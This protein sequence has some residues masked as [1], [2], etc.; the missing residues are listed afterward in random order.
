MLGWAVSANP[1]HSLA[2]IVLRVMRLRPLYVIGCFAVLGVVLLIANR[3]MPF[4]RNDLVYARAAQHVI[5]HGY[6]PRPIVA[7]SSLSYDKPVGFAWLGAPF[8]RAFGSHVGLRIVSFLGVLLFLLASWRFVRALRVLPEEELP[9]R[10]AE[11]W[12]L[13]LVAFNPIVAYQVWSAHPDA[14]FAALVLATW[15]LAIELVREPQRAVWRKATLLALL[16]TSGLVLKN[17]ALILLA[18][19]PLYVALNLRALHAHG[20]R[21][22]QLVIALGAALFAGAGFAW[23]AKSGH[24]PFAHIAG[25]GGGAGQYGKGELA[26]GALGTLLQ[27]AL[28]LVLNLGLALVFLARRV[29]LRRELVIPLVAFLAPYVAGLMAFPTTYYNMRYFL[30]LLPLVA[31]ACVHGARAAAPGFARSIFA[32][33]LALGLLWIAV[34]N[35]APLHALAEPAIPAWTFTAGY[36]KQG[37][38]DNL[39]M[40]Q[41][42][43]R[44]AEIERANASVGHGGVLYMVDCAYYR[45]ATHAVYE[46]AGLLRADIQTRYVRGR[47]LALSEDH[48]WA[49]VFYGDAHALARAGTITE[50]APNLV[51]IERASN[52]PGSAPK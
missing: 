7:D 14:L 3:A 23:A 43:A 41:H 1:S 12:V 37:M 11:T 50:L 40:S 46:D 47:D 18:N 25:E 32:A 28:C 10:R 20:R 35:V 49:W 13:A 8:V 33:Q 4:V 38:L 36:G 29:N 6:D 51:R 42:R 2:E 15:T 21:P 39:R 24:N 34:F 52:E 19:V 44:A 16:F 48:A 45:D 26:I 17:Y 9:R 30:P 31:L 5:E 27:V 22:W